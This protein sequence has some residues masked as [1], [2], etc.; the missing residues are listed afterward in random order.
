VG[1]A[2]AVTVEGGT[3][4]LSYQ[5]RAAALSV[6]GAAFDLTEPRPLKLT[7]DDLVLLDRHWH[8]DDHRSTELINGCIYFTPTRYIPRCRIAQEIWI[9][10]REA[11]ALVAPHLSVCTR[12]SVEFS[13]YDLPLPDIVLT[14]EGRGEGFIPAASVA[15]VVE[16]AETALDFY[17]ND[18]LQLYAKGGVP[19]Y[20]IVDV[21]AQVIHQLWTPIGNSYAE[22]RETTFGQYVPVIT[23]S[24]LR[25]DTAVL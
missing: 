12:G 2:G 14:N 13:P 3:Q 15:L 23:T 16:V 7:V 8:D 10:L 19:E 4:R 17:L 21:N 5:R 6:G 18:K 1:E 22:E 9:Q 11:A 25:V 24:G 20:W